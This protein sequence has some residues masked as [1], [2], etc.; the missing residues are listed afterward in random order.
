MNDA[1]RKNKKRKGEIVTPRIIV[2]GMVF[3]FCFLAAAFF[4]AWCGIQSRRMGYE[5]VQAREQ[6]EKLLDFQKKL[7][8][9]KAR[10]TSP[11]MLRRYATSELNLD[12]P[13]PEQIIVMP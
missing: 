12:T 1:R 3:L 13:K 8:I 11:Q 9:E 5:I 4:D 2:F 6:Q 10:L 7:K